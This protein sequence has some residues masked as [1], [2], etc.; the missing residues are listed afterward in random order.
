M[1]NIGFSQWWSYH[2]GGP[3]A[4]YFRGLRRWRHLVHSI[5]VRLF[6]FGKMGG[7]LWKW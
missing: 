7:K 2:F 5:G 6:L 1:Q 3:C 4:E